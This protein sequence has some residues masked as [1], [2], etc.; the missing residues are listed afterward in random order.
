MVSSASQGAVTS[1]P[2]LDAQG[3]D[4]PGPNN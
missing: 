3:P 1:F 2:D 4:S